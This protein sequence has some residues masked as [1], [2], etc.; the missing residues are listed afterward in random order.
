MK[1][2]RVSAVVTNLTALVVTT[3]LLFS[4]ARS[5]G[6]PAIHSMIYHYTNS[7]TCLICHGVNGLIPGEDRAGEI[8]NTSHWSWTVTNRPAGHAAQVMGKRNII[9]NYCIAT[10]SNEPRCTSCHIGVGWRDNSFDFNS[11]TNI[12]CLVCHDTTGT[13][14]K[15]PAGAGAPDPAVDMSYVVKRA[16][17]TSRATCGACHFYGGGGDAV[18][19]GDLDSTLTNPTRDLDVHMGVDGA[20]MT[21][22][23]CHQSTEPGATSHDMVGSRYSKAY[24]DNRLCEDCHTSTPH[25]NLDSGIYYDGHS[26]R[27]AC[28]TCH[29]PYFARGGKATKMTWD[30][31]TAGI[32]G[33][34]GSLQTIKDTA[35]N[36]TYD[37]MK[38]SFTWASNVVPEYVWFNGNVIWN[39][40]TNTINPSQTLAINQLQGNKD[41]SRARIIPVKRF[42]AVQPYDAV[43]NTL[44]VPHLFALNAND[45]NA[46]WKGYD[47]TNAI[48]AGMASVGKTFSGKMGWANT[49]MY[50]VQ[51]H[52]VAPKEKALT[53][54]DCHRKNGRI[55]FAQLGYD[56]NR[57]ARLQDLNMIIGLDHAGRFGTNYAGPASCLE[58]HPGKD[59]E[60][61]GSVHYAW[62]TPNAKLAYPGGG[63]HGML[64]RFCGLV[65]SSAMIN[66]YAD[67]G[68]YKDSGACGKCH[69]GDSLPLPDPATGQ[70]TRNQ[71]DGLDCLI[72]HASE[73]N[74]DMNGDGLYN[75]ADSEISHRLLLTNSVTGRRTWFQDRSL[76]AA[77]SVGWTVGAAQCLRCHEHG[78][79]AADYKRGTPF[80]P[81]HDVHAA[82]GL[83]CT[84]CHKVDDHKIAR[85]SRVTDMHAWERQSVEVDC[86]NCH[87]TK[88]HTNSALAMLNNHTSLIA[89]EACHI[90]WTSGALRRVWAPTFG[91]T[92]GPEANIPAYDATNNLFRPYSTYSGE[93][94]LR[95]VYRWFNGNESMLAE[96]VNDPAAWD[97]Q[98]ATKNTPGAKIYAFRAIINGMVMDR[99][100]FG[101]DPNF[102]TNF[103]ML[104]AMDAMAGPLKQ[105]GF[106]RS[107]GLNPQERAALAQYPNLLNFD[108]ETYVRT[109]NIQEA[110]NVGLGRMGVMMNG[111]DAWGMTPEQL[112][113][114]GANFWSGDVLG[115]DMPNN[116]MDPL[117]N[118]LAPP[119]EATGSFISLSHAIKRNGALNCNDC[120]S[121][122]SVLDFKALSYTSDRA[123][124]LKSVLQNVPSFSIQP[125]GSG[126]K[127][128]WYS[129]PGQTYELQ[130][131]TNLVEGIW[132]PIGSAIR[133]TNSSMESVVSPAQFPAEGHMFFRVK[134]TQ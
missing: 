47:W 14:K 30:W 131:T 96:P 100:G 116:P 129:V 113:G 36:V 127:L 106:M 93:Y 81:E 41:Q 126:I 132:F 24:P 62:R 57:V 73:G 108:V 89:C 59:T 45:T 60:V 55:P 20:N 15:S 104:A 110:I 4:T 101:Y 50:W 107:T 80:D 94:N 65:G 39:E 63:S 84:D 5:V 82:A 75:A 27:V 109:G 38:G 79:A 35:G 70:F 124:F 26:A 72:C 68:A 78:Q 3:L 13:Y 125:D 86:S 9:N 32:K 76:R 105:M 111:Q 53:C 43:S 10:A 130:G 25:W 121:P 1:N 34:N 133:A 120:H 98:I 115:L 40:L 87:G 33:T 69:V 17:K 118:P 21:C 22:A 67:L 56:S 102:N 48:N 71:K 29:V 23:D 8:K 12:D 83:D 16:G 97:G 54:I 19:H 95:P 114:V 103:T 49:E 11:I 123:A 91:V 7:S 51:N 2:W 74:Y 18:K 44:V 119:T 46:Y 92:D 58:C 52:M 85:G 28:Q 112:S 88:P 99:R 31:S 42:S 66:Y 128:R 134:A 37:T 6:Q 90:P 122:N 61:M 77:E 64:D 117:F